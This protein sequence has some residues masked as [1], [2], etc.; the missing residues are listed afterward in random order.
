MR[1]DNRLSCVLHVLLHMAEAGGPMTS[2][3]LARAL[4]T[5]PVVVRRLMGGL[6]EHGYVH[7]EKGHGGGWTL[8]CQLD[9]VTLRDI[10]EALDAPRLFAIGNR[11]EETEC[12][13]EEAV[14]HAMSSVLADVKAQF[15]ARFGQITLAALHADFHQRL[16]ER[17]APTTLCK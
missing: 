4:N 7:S 13:V 17:H 8:S 6:R 10:Y 5:N 14:N 1:Q 11:S 9:Q 15:L 3:V 2:E 12:L 16:A